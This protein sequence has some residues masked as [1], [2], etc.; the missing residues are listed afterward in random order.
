MDDKLCVPNQWP[1]MLIDLLVE[2]GEVLLSGVLGVS[3]RTARDLA[4]QGICQYS[5]DDLPRR[6]WPR[7]SSTS[8]KRGSN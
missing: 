6:S 7:S 1:L 5:F 3:A 8:A 4:F 2:E